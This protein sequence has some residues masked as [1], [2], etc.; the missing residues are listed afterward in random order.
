MICQSL[1][2]ES[3]PCFCGG[4]TS[5]RPEKVTAVLNVELPSE[6]HAPPVPIILIAALIFVTGVP[7]TL[8]QAGLISFL[9]NYPLIAA[10]HSWSLGAHSLL[11]LTLHALQCLLSSPA[12]SIL[13]YFILWCDIGWPKQRLVSCSRTPQQLCSYVASRQLHYSLTLVGTVCLLCLNC[14]TR[15]ASFSS[16]PSRRL[17]L[18]LLTQT[19]SPPRWSCPRHTPHGWSMCLWGCWCCRPPRW[20]SQCAT[21][22][23]WRKTAPATWPRPPWCRP[24]CSRS[25]PAPSSSSLRTV[26]SEG[27]GRVRVRAEVFL[28]AVLSLLSLFS[29]VDFALLGTRSHISALKVSDCQVLSASPLCHFTP[30]VVPRLSY[31]Q[32]TLCHRQNSVCAQWTS[33]WRRRLWTIP[34][35]PWSWPF[36]QGSTHCRT[37]CSMLPCPTWTQPPI[38]WHECAASASLY[39]CVCVLRNHE[40]R[41]LSVCQGIFF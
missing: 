6:I 37:I 20:C 28:S 24:R 39:V 18:R 40:L 14:L 10:W 16:C 11:S 26:S 4:L 23:P 22:A 35:G 13:L 2:P 9:F 21:P 19:Q 27:R 34:W 32:H 7:P 5:M 33:C 17:P 41:E 15:S 25:S 3:V 31:L 12:L 1:L 8:P 30:W 36:L 38:R 29:G